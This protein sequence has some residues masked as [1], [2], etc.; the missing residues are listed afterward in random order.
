MK[1]KTQH[2]TKPIRNYDSLKFI[3]LFACSLVNMLSYSIPE[4]GTPLTIS[5]LTSFVANNHIFLI[6]LMFLIASVI[7]LFLTPYIS[8]IFRFINIKVIFSVGIIINGLGFICFGFTQYIL[9]SEAG[10]LVV[11]YT[12]QTAVTLGSMIFSTIGIPLVI[13]QWF[14]KKQKGLAIGISTSAIGLGDMIWQPI[15]QSALKSPSLGYSNNHLAIWNMYFIFGSI[16][17]VLGILITLIMIQVPKT[18]LYKNETNQQQFGEVVIKSKYD[19]GPGFQVLKRNPWFWGF[20]LGFFIT[21][22]G[23]GTWGNMYVS[24]L[25][26]GLEW[27]NDSSKYNIIGYVGIFFASGCIVGN[28][29]GGTLFDKFGSAKIWLFACIMR[30]IGMFLLMLS[31][32]LTYAIFG[33]GL[34]C[35]LGTLSYRTGRSF[36]VLDLFKKRDDSQIVSAIAIAFNLGYSLS[37]PILTIISETSDHSYIFS[38]LCHHNWLAAWIFA[39][40]LLVV[41]MLITWIMIKKI[42]QLGTKGL[43]ITTINDFNLFKLRDSFWIKFTSYHL[44]YFGYSKTI[45]KKWYLSH[46]NK[47]VDEY[48]STGSKKQETLKNKAIKELKQL[49]L[50]AKKELSYLE[51]HSSKNLSKYQKSNLIFRAKKFKSY[52]YYKI[53]CIQYNYTKFSVYYQNPLDIIC[54]ELLTNIQIIY[55]GKDKKAHQLYYLLPKSLK[56]IAL[57]RLNKYHS[58]YVVLQDELLTSHNSKKEAV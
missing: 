41:G 26:D 9:H 25:E 56:W 21:S 58:N 13:N 43:E 24:Y 20:I 34:L 5:S 35:G 16:S 10:A 7:T 28:L 2:F 37:I 23:V 57:K 6:G 54:A 3:V 22:M 15:I 46:L 29:V 38:V 33:A 50:T 18:D 4:Y 32:K 36:I 49:L 51:I 42:N 27:V 8:K 44:W 40:S 39:I 53:H 17:I 1:T 12:C 14:S 55:E 45:F 11:V 30:I 19:K 48:S 47:L 31:A 52:M